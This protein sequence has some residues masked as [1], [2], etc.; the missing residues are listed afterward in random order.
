MTTQAV[1]IRSRR[2]A[3]GLDRVQRLPFFHLSSNESGVRAPTFTISSPERQHLLTFSR[4]VFSFEPGLI[5][6][7]QGDAGRSMTLA[8]FL[9]PLSRHGGSLSSFNRGGGVSR[10]DTHFGHRFLR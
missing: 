8:R 4:L 1:M 7:F 3:R 2:A 5:T 6:S 10:R 9:R